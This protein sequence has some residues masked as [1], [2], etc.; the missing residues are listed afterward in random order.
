[1]IGILV[2]IEELLD[3]DAALATRCKQV[4]HRLGAE[5]AIH[6]DFPNRIAGRRARLE[7]GERIDEGS[8]G[9]ADLDDLPPRIRRHLS[10][11]HMS[12]RPS[13]TGTRSRLAAF[14][15]RGLALPSTVTLRQCPINDTVQPSVAESDE[16]KPGGSCPGSAGK[17]KWH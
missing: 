9:H 7:P 16:G 5:L 12:D 15:P 13:R 2:V 3:V 1:M 17:E 6:A 4:G 10:N 11:L 8:S 14:C